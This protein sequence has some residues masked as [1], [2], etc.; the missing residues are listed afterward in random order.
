MMIPPQTALGAT[1]WGLS[2]LPGLGVIIAYVAWRSWQDA[3]HTK[4]V[5]QGGRPATPVTEG[6]NGDREEIHP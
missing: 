5:A 6:E 4:R 1:L 3:H 2:S